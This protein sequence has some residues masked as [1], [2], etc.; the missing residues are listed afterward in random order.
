[1]YEWLVVLFSLIF[2]SLICSEL[3]TIM[4]P[5]VNASLKVIRTSDNRNHSLY[6]HYKCLCRFTYIYYV[7][8]MW[9]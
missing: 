1:M 9:W 5:L 8:Y 4:L 6:L 7:S 2:S 3:E